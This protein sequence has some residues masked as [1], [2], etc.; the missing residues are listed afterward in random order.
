M[1]RGS[2]KE[3]SLNNT[4]YLYLISSCTTPLACG[5]FVVL[6]GRGTNEVRHYIQVCLGRIIK[7]VAHP[8][9]LTVPNW[10]LPYR[11]S[12]RKLKVCS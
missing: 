10:R 9:I 1:A 12:F 5:K 8:E 6:V 3:A 7:M 11:L 4:F 2:S